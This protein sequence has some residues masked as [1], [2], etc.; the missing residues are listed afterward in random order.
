MRLYSTANKDK[1]ILQ[2]RTES[3]P[4]FKEKSK[5]WNSHFDMACILTKSVCRFLMVLSLKS[6]QQF[7]ET[8]V[9]GLVLKSLKD[10]NQIIV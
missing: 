7:I 6:G 8:S 4:R 9:K 2:K 3:L 10:N 5:G 1:H